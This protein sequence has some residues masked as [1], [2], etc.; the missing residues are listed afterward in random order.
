MTKE[1]S[2]DT[3]TL[4]DEE[5]SAVHT[6]TQKELET[7][8]TAPNR[9]SYLEGLHIGHGLYKD[10]DVMYGFGPWTTEI[11]CDIRDVTESTLGNS[12]FCSGMRDAYQ[13]RC[14]D[15]R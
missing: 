15:G 2:C 1:N 11:A 14:K 8:S 12:H 5:K 7:M 9:Q 3:F 4:S 13:N 10:K 6:S